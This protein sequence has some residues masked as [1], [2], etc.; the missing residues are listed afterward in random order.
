MGWRIRLG[1]RSFDLKHKQAKLNCLGDAV[2]RIASTRLTVLEEYEK[3]LRYMSP[4]AG[5]EGGESDFESDSDLGLQPNFPA[6]G[7]LSPSAD[8]PDHGPSICPRAVYGPLLLE[9]TGRGRARS[10]DRVQR[11][12]NQRRTTWI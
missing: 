7:L 4:T 2:S 3:I 6:P 10:P 12:P 8:D 11:C 5:D 1:E 9:G